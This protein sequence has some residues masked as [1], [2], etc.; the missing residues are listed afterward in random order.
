MP[1]QTPHVLVVCTSH[2]R[3]DA[4]ERTGVW[5]EEFA[6]PY[7]LM[8]AEGIEVTVASP[9]GGAVPIDPRSAPDERLAPPEQEAM[10]RLEESVR[11][12]EL[13]LSRFD[14]VYF[15]GGH[16]AMYDLATPAVGRVVEAFAQAAKPIAAVCHGPAAFVEAKRAGDGEAL[17]KDR[18]ISAFTND[19]ETEVGL[20]DRMPFLLETQLHEL[21]AEV[22][23]GE[24]FRAHTVRDGLLITGQNPASSEEIAKLLVSELVPRQRSGRVTP[25]GST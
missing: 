1:A 22:V 10:D 20:A 9:S 17:I 5:F 7:E 19:E 21:G 12:D 3:I 16:G 18:K 23:S 24:P 4:K 13:D 8:R 14:A 15:P 2:D 6:A 25:P 11:L